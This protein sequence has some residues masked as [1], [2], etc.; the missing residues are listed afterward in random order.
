MKL[1]A[2]TDTVAAI[3]TGGVCHALIKWFSEGR[4]TPVDEL[5]DEIAAVID[6]IQHGL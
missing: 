4:R 5:F 6:V 1:P 2:S 3:L